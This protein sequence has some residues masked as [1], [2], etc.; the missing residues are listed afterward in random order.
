MGCGTSSAGG[1]TSGEEKDTGEQLKDM[2][3][4]EE[5]AERRNADGGDEDFFETTVAQGESFMASKPWKG[6]VAEPSS[7]LPLNP[8][9][10][11]INFELEYA[12]GYRT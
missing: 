6:Q 8:E 1:A 11:N 9:K 3:D 5:G 7:H 10:P 12:Y 2:S 4:N